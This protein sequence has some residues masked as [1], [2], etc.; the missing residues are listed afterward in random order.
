MYRNPDKRLDTNGNNWGYVGKYRNVRN[1]IKRHRSKEIRTIIKD[2]MKD[3]T[4][5]F[6]NK[7][8]DEEDLDDFDE[9]P[10]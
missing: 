7:I 1:R 10:Y 2:H 3:I 6:N 9:T 8:I 5:A 4:L